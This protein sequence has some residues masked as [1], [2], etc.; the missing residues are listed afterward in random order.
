M[1]RRMQLSGVLKMDV[2]IE[3][4]AKRCFDKLII[5]RVNKYDLHENFKS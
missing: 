1:K 5:V 3:F 4:P 2:N